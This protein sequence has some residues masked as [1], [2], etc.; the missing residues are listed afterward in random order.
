MAEGGPTGALHL[1]PPLHPGQDEAMWVDTYALYYSD[2]D[3]T[4]VRYQDE[5]GIEVSVGVC[6][7]LGLPGLF[8]VN[9]VWKCYLTFSAPG[10]F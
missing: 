7:R 9:S 6:R 4:Y 10:S 8:L 3:A 2:D 5:N 1:P